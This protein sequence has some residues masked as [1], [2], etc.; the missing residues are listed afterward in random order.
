MDEPKVPPTLQ[1][2]KTLTQ[3]VVRHDQELQ[4]LRRMDQFI[5]FL[6]HEPQGA[7][8]ILLQETETWK[9][10]MEQGKHSQHL[11]LRQHLM[12][13]LLRN[14]QTRAGQI[15][16]AKETDQLH[17]TSVTKGVILADK[18]FPFHKW[19]PQEQKLVIDKKPALSSTKMH[20]NLTE[21]LEM[22]QDRELIIRFHALRAPTDQQRVIPWRLQLNLRSDRP[23]ELLHYLTH[24][25]VWMTVGASMKQHTLTQTPMATTL[26][27]MLGS[28]KNQNKGKGRGKHSK[29]AK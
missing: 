3:L 16:A 7:L 20:Q 25:S 2:L 17:Q 24:S 28:S 6:N 11:A 27:S 13:A 18:S 14:M 4:S 5:L 26:Q 21:L 23:F 19:D 29:P 9:A 12:I 22:M 1:L 10:Q 8:H 15:V